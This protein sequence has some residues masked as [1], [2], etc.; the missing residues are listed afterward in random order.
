MNL[1]SQKATVL[2]T[3][4]AG[5][6]GS[7]LVDRLVSGGYG[8]RVLDNLSTGKF[9][10]IA[11]HLGSGMVD[12]VK[13]DVRDDELVAKSVQGVDVVFHLAAVTGVPFSVL[14]P[15]L[16][17]DVNVWGT[18]NLL[19]SSVREKV[20]RFVFVSSGAVY[21]EPQRLPVKESDATG[22]ISPF[23][24][25]KVAAEGFCLGLHARRFLKSVVFRLFNVYGPRESANGCCGVITKFF[26]HSRKGLPLTIYGDGLQTRDFVHVYD[27][28]DAMAMVLD[29][30]G[31]DGQ[32]LNIGSGQ[33]TTLKELAA[34]I[35]K[36]RGRVSDLV[37]AA[38][39]PGDIRQSFAD[40]SKARRLLGYEP[41][42]TLTEGLRGLAEEFRTQGLS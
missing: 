17:A 19:V 24:D 11:G 16:T 25:S 32:V 18:L 37:H 21:G 5:F 7:H 36:F 13:G 30:R 40:I 23:A 15:E 6:I 27:V 35:L 20:A 28:V 12:F 29:D 22:P 3:G 8:V 10:N 39:R 33:P 42:V 38:W 26:D 41:K 9:D 31:V 2:V 4:G 14:N 34:M 1:P